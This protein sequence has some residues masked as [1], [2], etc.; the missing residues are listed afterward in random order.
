MQITE[1]L[2]SIPVDAAIGPF[3]LLFA[4]SVFK[5]GFIPVSLAAMALLTASVAFLYPRLGIAVFLAAFPFFPVYVLIPIV[6]SVK[7]S[8]IELLSA[9]LLLPIS[10]RALLLERKTAMSKVDWVVLAFLFLSSIVRF[11]NASPGDTSSTGLNALSYP[12]FNFFLPYFTVSRFVRGRK[13]LYVVLKVMFFISVAFILLA[14]F[15][16]ETKYNVFLNLPYMNNATAS[17]W[18]QY[19]IRGDTLRVKTSFA[20]PLSF[21]TYIDAMGLMVFAIIG[22][23][24][25][26]AFKMVAVA[27]MI[28]ASI[29]LFLTQGRG[30]IIIFVA[31]VLLYYLR[32]FNVKYTVFIVTSAVLLLYALTALVPTLSE[33]YLA[34]NENLANLYSRVDLWTF[35]INSLSR[36]SIFGVSDVGQLIWLPSYLSFDI[37]SWYLQSLVFNGIIVFALHMFLVVLLVRMLFRQIHMDPRSYIVAL[38]VFAF[39]M[40]Y[41]SVSFVG[42]GPVFFWIFCGLAVAQES[43]LA[44]K[45]REA[46]GG[47]ALVAGI[48]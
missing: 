47:T 17:Q 40:N 8:G 48:Q 31:L 19:D 14:M 10:I 46:R 15:E 27:Y 32:N 29:V 9:T 26:T 38:P 42:T 33:T 35:A 30:P 2:R 37:V 5:V 18:R 25:R 4:I 12:F 36:V 16:Y 43:L 41:F 7:L 34:N 28:A 45:T 22:Q 3:L 39:L 44:K 20:Q 23:L 1:R 21:A 13:D 24:K 6:G 11:F